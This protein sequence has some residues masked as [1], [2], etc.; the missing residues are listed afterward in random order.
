MALTRKTPLPLSVEDLERLRGQLE[1]YGFERLE[2]IL[3]IRVPR[4]EPD[5][6]NDVEEAAEFVG[7][8]DIEGATVLLIGDR[9][10][11]IIPASALATA[12]AN[13]VRL[14]AAVAQETRRAL[15]PGSHRVLTWPGDP[16]RRSRLVVR[17]PGSVAEVEEDGFDALAAALAPLAEEPSYRN[18]HAVHLVGDADEAR[19]EGGL[20]WDDLLRQ[21]QEA[22][23]RH[24]LAHE[25]ASKVAVPAPPPPDPQAPALAALEARLQQLGY[26]VRIRPPSRVAVDLAAERKAPPQRIVAFVTPLLDAAVATAALE[27]TRSLQADIGLVVAPETDRDG[28]R[29]LVATR[30]RHL[31]A[32]AIAT[33]QT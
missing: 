23:E 11:L 33:L 2:G 3:A 32:D 28:A 30:V 17:L 25:L 7:G 13:R 14:D 15:A 19:L 26:V 8:P 22:E 4:D 10:E 21:H 18:V 1:S 29:K 16:R 24:T 12:V 6:V 27:A 20:F 9:R 31:T 5:L